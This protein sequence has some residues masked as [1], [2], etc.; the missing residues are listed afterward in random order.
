MV[1]AVDRK[2]ITR[3]YDAGDIVCCEILDVLPQC[4]KMIVGMKGTIT[5]PGLDGKYT[6]GLTTSDSFPDIYK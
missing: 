3:N 4:T 1:M 6:L 2:G 5:S